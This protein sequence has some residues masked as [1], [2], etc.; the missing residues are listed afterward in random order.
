MPAQWSAVGFDNGGEGVAY[1]DNVPGNAG[2]QLRPNED[3]DI[4]SSGGNYV[5]NNF[6]TGEWLL[7]TVNVQAT[8]NYDIRLFVSSEFANSGFHVEIDDTD[9]TGRVTVPNTGNWNTFQWVGKQAIRLTAG[10]HVLK[11]VSD[12]QYFNLR[13]VWV[14]ARPSSTPFTGKP[15]QLP[16]LIEAENFDRG[17]E[18]VAYHDNIAGNAGGQYRTGEDVDIIASTDTVPGTGGFVVNNFETGEWLAYTVNSNGG[19]FDVTLRA[20]TSPDFPDAAYH[21]EID[22]VNVSGT[23]VL[24]DTGGWNNFQWVGLRPVQ[25]P[26]GERV[27]KIVSE[28][29]YFNLNAI[30]VAPRP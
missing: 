18:G 16:A 15:V 2:G 26:A 23:I 5:V 11:V 3:V 22:G 13:D 21:I 28:R 10:Q 29:Q 30:N 17:G 14:V 27:L 20:A 6:E 8:G 7:Y 24:P 12:Q 1:H 4:I 25:I 9:V 19:S